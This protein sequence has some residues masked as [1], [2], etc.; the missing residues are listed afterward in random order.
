MNTTALCLISCYDN[1]YIIEDLAG[2]SFDLTKVAS[3]GAV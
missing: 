3:K 2:N 1:K